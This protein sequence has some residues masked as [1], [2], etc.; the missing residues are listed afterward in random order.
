MKK[1]VMETS[2]Q[3]VESCRHSKK[4]RGIKFL[5]KLKELLFAHCHPRVPM[6]TPNYKED[7]VYA[8]TIGRSLER[9]RTMAR[10]KWWKDNQYRTATPVPPQ[11]VGQAMRPYTYQTH[12][13]EP[14][15]Q[16]LWPN[17]HIMYQTEVPGLVLSQGERIGGFFLARI[18]Y[19][20][21]R[22]WISDTPTKK[23]SN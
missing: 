17:P 9:N 13:P 4:T 7:L 11:A 16:S 10:N 23:L 8:L 3:I 1:S 22:I 6:P 5:H 2:Q 19:A 20:F 14:V 15:H 21:E 12:V 18:Y